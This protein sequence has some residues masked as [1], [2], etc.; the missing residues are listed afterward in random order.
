MLE[1]SKKKLHFSYNLMRNDE[2]KGF[3][4]SVRYYDFNEAKMYDFKK[5]KE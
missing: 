2:R 1:L 5:E 3:L 4:I